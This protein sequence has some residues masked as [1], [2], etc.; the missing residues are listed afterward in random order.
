MKDTCR[1]LSKVYLYDVYVAVFVSQCRTILENRACTLS[2]IRA[3]CPLFQIENISI[4]DQQIYRSNVT[5]K[6]RT[7]S[8]P[9]AKSEFSIKIYSFT[10]RRYW[11]TNISIPPWQEKCCNPAHELT[12][13]GL[14]LLYVICELFL[15]LSIDNSQN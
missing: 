11:F 3:Q 13:N 7:K 1:L 10:L 4:R 6:A 2:S 15:S 9:Y 14:C 8:P 5:I 12:D